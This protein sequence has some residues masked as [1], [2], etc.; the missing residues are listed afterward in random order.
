MRISVTPIIT[1][2]LIAF[3]IPLIVCIIW[4]TSIIIFIGG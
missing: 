1:P 4:G 3:R 2:L